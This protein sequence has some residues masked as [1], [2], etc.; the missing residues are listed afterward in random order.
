PPKVL[1]PGKK[2]LY[3]PPPSVATQRATVLRPLFP[4]PPV[5]T[6]Q[7]YATPCKF[8][9]QSVRL[10]GVVAD[11]THWELLDKSLIKICF[12]QSDFRGGGPLDMDGAREPLTIGDGHDL[13]SL[14]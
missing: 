4:G 6:D 1:E 7:L 8:R 2:S 9:I 5:R 11:E 3:L 10:V 12:H 13:R 14:A